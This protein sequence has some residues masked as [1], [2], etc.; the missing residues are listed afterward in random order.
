MDTNNNRC[1]RAKKAVACTAWPTLPFEAE[2]APPSHL[3]R[4]EQADLI[5]IC[6]HGPETRREELLL[7]RL[8]EVEAACRVLGQE[9]KWD[10][11]AG[12]TVEEIQSTEGPYNLD[13]ILS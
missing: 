6:A 13:D 11:G 10:R 3:N 1:S 9:L 7:L 5:E 2:L 4:V 8:A 12:V